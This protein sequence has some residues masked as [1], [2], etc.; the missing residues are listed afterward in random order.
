M[1]NTSA[2]LTIQ[3]LLLVALGV[4]PALAGNNYTRI[5]LCWALGAL[6]RTIYFAEIEGREDRQTSFTSLLDI[7]AIDH[8]PVECRTSDLESHRAWRVTLMNEWSLSKFEIVNTT[9]M[10]DLDY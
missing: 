7:S 5:Q 8:H 9:F 1:A 4:T 6:D 10:S 2:R 3:W